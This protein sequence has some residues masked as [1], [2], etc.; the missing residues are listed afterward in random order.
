MSKVFLKLILIIVL[1]VDSFAQL[2]PESY[3]LPNDNNYINKIS[4]SNPVSNSIL[5]IITTGDTVW[6]GTSRGVSVSF[7]RGVSWNNFYNTTAFGTDN[8]S[9]I[10]YFEG[11]LW[12]ATAK[13]VEGVAGEDVAAGT[14]LKYTTDNGL[15]W[16]SI[17]QPVDNE[18]DTVE[19]YGIN[20]I[21]A[22]PVTVPEENSLRRRSCLLPEKGILI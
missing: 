17:P 15:T 19:V 22:L 10:G 7:D 16:N 2:L 4:A 3:N 11:T 13:T 1:F 6:L 21:P 20:N 14:G 5:D 8:V 9:A 12:A 18:N